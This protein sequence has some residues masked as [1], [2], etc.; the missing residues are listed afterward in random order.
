V[1]EGIGWN[2]QI[3]EGD[4]ILRRLTLRRGNQLHEAGQ[5]RA[6]KH[7]DRN[8]PVD[9]GREDCAAQRGESQQD[10]RT[11]FDHAQRGQGIFRE[12]A[13]APEDDAQEGEKEHRRVDGQDQRVAQPLAEDDLGAMQRLRDNDG[14]GIRLYL[15]GS[16]VDAQHDGQGPAEQIGGPYR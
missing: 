3:D 5:G 14:K 9:K 15:A 16:H 13:R 10:E 8:G 4:D 6:D 12:V 2:Y 7:H 1:P 11:H